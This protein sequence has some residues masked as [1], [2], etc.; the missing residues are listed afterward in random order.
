MESVVSPQ[1]NYSKYDY[2]HPSYEFRQISKQ[3]GNNTQ[4]LNAN[5]GQEDGMGPTKD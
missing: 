2:R 5:G 3:T 4:T 1:L